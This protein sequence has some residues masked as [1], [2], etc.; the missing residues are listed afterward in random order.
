MQQ[1]PEIA[2]CLAAGGPLIMSTRGRGPPLPDWLPP[3]PM[4]MHAC[5]E[6]AFA[7][8]VRPECNEVDHGVLFAEPRPVV[9]QCLRKAGDRPHL[10]QLLPT[11][12]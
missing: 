6:A 11:D 4:H 5:M 1:V 8:V 3:L 7:F 12:L 2:V 9:L 10:R